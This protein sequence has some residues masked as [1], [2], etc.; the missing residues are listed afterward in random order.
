MVAQLEIYCLLPNHK[1]YLE[2]Y[3]SWRNC[4]SVLKEATMVAS[5]ISIYIVAGV[6]K[7][8]PSYTL[9]NGVAIGSMSRG[10]T[11]KVN[12]LSA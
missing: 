10:D 5:S 6:Y 8:S 9:L 12:C 1:V 2:L 7:E 4:I 11:V 3:K